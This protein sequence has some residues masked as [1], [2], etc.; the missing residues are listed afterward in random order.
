MQVVTLIIRACKSECK[1]TQRRDDSTQTDEGLVD[2]PSL[3]QSLTLGTSR[4]GT[5]TAEEGVC[6]CVCSSYTSYTACVC[7]EAMWAIV[8]KH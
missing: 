6:V 2:A 3:L 1:L 5:L 4:S 7:V 8:T